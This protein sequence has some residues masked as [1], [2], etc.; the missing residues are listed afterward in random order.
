MSSRTPPMLVLTPPPS[1]DHVVLGV[2]EQIGAHPSSDNLSSSH[3]IGERSFP[4]NDEPSDEEDLED[5]GPEDEK[6]G[7]HDPDRQTP[8]PQ[9]AGKRSQ[10]K[11][12]RKRRN[13][14]LERS[15]QDTSGEEEKS[16]SHK[17]PPKAK[18]KIV[19]N[20]EECDLTTFNVKSVILMQS[21][22]RR[23]LA[24]KEKSKILH[25]R[26]QMKKRGQVAQEML[27]VRFSLHPVL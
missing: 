26:K 6:R 2:K 5:P 12:K 4:Q 19:W 24:K 15:L 21:C 13:I 10:P 1:E 7:E 3:P 8:P 14:A 25:R 22:I 11:Q 23:W 18:P 20:V 27:K 16:S 17:T 9:V